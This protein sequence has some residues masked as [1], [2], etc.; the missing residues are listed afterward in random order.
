MKAHITDTDLR[1]LTAILINWQ[2]MRADQEQLACRM[3]TLLGCDREDVTDL[4]NEYLSIPHLLDDQQIEVHREE[5]CR[6]WPR[7]RVDGETL[8][9]LGIIVCGV[10]SVASAAGVGF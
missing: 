9:V 4:L 3:G 6:P 2:Q 7:P 10:A 5:Y 8:L 1:E